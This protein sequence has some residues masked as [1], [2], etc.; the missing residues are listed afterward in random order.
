MN[1]CIKGKDG[2]RAVA[3]LFRTAGYIGAERGC[4]HDGMTG[5]AD[6]VGVPF[7]W[8]EVKREERL[9]VEAAMQQAER[10]SAA[11]FQNTGEDTLAVVI[12]RKNREEWKCT[13]RL[14]DFLSMCGSM[15]FTVTI[16]V[17]GLVTMKWSEWIKV[18]MAY[19]TERRA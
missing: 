13:M 6:V 8:I 12:H 5:H 1:S 19:E 4:Q 17:D 16:P 9:N 15:P 11:L 3:K 10:D 14:L 7:L 2:E 18:F